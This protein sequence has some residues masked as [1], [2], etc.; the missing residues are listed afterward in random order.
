MSL[1][2]ILAAII[3]L[4]T[5][6]A[7]QMPVIVESQVTSF[8]AFPPDYQLAGTFYI[9][10]LDHQEGSLEYRQYAQS[11]SQNLGGYGL[12]EVNDQSQADFL[13]TFDYDVDE[14][15][16]VADSTPI[17]GRT[18]GTLAY[19]IYGVV[20]SRAYS[21]VE[22]TRQLTFQIAYG[23]RSAA[24]NQDTVFEANVVSTGESN[25]F[26]VVSEC[27]FNALFDEFPGESGRTLLVTVPYQDCAR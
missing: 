24:D 19:P 27:L 16:T 11:I 3:L 21:R 17:Y 13:M 7:C 14:G 26:S 2:R 18:G 6:S 5:I 1:N 8:H 20:G 15:R 4:F 23:S 12:E 25:S 9:A 22:F 10:P